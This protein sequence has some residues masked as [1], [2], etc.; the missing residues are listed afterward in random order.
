ILRFRE[1]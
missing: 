1:N